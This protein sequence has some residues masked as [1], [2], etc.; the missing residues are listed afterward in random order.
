MDAIAEEAGVSKLTVYNNFGSKEALFREVIL[1]KCAQFSAP[2]SFLALT[3]T[4]PR[5][6]LSQIANGFVRLMLQPEVVAM[7]RVVIGEA[8]RNSKVAELLNDAGARPT[9]AAFTEL[10]KVWIKAGKLEIPAPERASD[11]FFHMLKGHMVQEVTLNLRAV[12][13]NA[14]IKRHVDDCVDMFLRAY[15]VR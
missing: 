5:S 3:D 15:E 6:A 4:E 13:G 9:L 8:G 11:H 1:D 14:E 2:E 10:L 12:P 7:H